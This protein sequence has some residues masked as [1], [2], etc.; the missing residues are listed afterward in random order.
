MATS[1]NRSSR[2]NSKKNKIFISWS[3]ANSKEIAKALKNKLEKNVFSGTGLECFVSDE[4]IVSG[5]D[6][7]NKINKE[8]KSCKIG[9]LCI[10][11][12]NINAPWIYYE[13]GAMIAQSV[14]TIPLL[15]S[16]DFNALK[17]TPLNGKQ[18]VNFYDQAKFIKM[19]HDIYKKMEYNLLQEKQIETIAKATYNE[20]KVEVEPV[21]KRLKDLRVFNAK[22][23]YPSSVTTIKRNSIYISVPMASIQKDLEYSE[24]REFLIDLKQTLK[25]VGFK[26]IYC[27]MIDKEDKDH[28]D[29]KT[30]AIKENFTI[31]KQVD[32]IL[33][34]YPKKLPSS[35]LVEIGYGIAL[36]KKMVIFYSDG[37]PYMLERVGNYIQNVS[38]YHFKSLNEISGI[39]EKNGMVLFEGEPEE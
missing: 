9:I 13:A 12:E 32:S 36:S 5:T 6:W 10:T 31:L 38:T 26:D 16:C 7:W 34:V 14:Q 2:S 19:I 8:L 28:F 21:L 25:K 29:G 20:L 24:L 3:G 17:D 1:N 27:P 39:I 33:V 11:K 4:D 23:V 15:V 37:L 18:A 35:T 22:Y 30:K